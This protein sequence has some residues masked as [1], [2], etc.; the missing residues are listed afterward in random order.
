MIFNNIF[1]DRKRRFLDLRSKELKVNPDL[2]V[3]GDSIHEGFNFPR[4]GVVSK[5]I[6]NSAISG[7]QI[8]CM[9][10]RLQVDV[11]NYHP[12]QCLFMGGINDIRQAVKD[13]I[14]IAELEQTINQVYADYVQIIEQLVANDIQI[15]PCLITR[16][17]EDRYN[18]EVIN[19]V[20]DKVNEKLENYGLIHGINFIN[21]NEVLCNQVGILSRDLS[22]DG[23]HPNDYGYLAMFK[24]LKLNK[25]LD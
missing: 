15:Y 14:S 7:D 4:Y 25:I 2:I 11:I 1:T 9:K 8:W 17:S 23:L 19:L 3:F 24:L 21:Y 22:N 13:N 10:E 20:V 18:Y 16:N 6:L 12:K 5:S